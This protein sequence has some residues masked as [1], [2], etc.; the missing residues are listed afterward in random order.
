ME[1][2]LIYRT[3]ESWCRETHYFLLSTNY[4]TRVLRFVWKT[5]NPGTSWNNCLRRSS[6]FEFCLH[7]C[8]L[9]FLTLASVQKYVTVHNVQTGRNYMTT[10]LHI[11]HWHSFC[12]AIY[13]DNS[14][15]TGHHGSFPQ[16]VYVVVISDFIG[17]ASANQLPSCFKTR[18]NLSK[19]VGVGE[20]MND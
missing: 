13:W 9:V 1:L 8:L 15:L 20:W 12:T 11:P 2:L 3:V 18:K 6:Y 17:S 16:A 14:Q 10:T 7:I 19:E 5:L 4:R